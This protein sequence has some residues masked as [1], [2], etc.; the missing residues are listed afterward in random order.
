MACGR[1][2]TDGGIAEL[3]ESAAEMGTPAP[4]V[5]GAVWFAVDGIGCNGTDRSVLRMKFAL[6]LSTK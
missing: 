6:V 2:E 3:K 1:L 5:G 4:V